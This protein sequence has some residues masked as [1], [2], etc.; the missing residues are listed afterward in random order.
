MSDDICTVLF[1]KNYLGDEIE[2]DGIDATRSTHEKYDKCVYLPEN[3]REVGTSQTG[4]RCEDNRTTGC[5]GVDWN[6]GW[7]A[8]VKR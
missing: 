3:A 4:S 7:R 8:I 6:H 5:E 2:E 1:N